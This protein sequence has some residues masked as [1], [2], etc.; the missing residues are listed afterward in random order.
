MLPSQKKLQN[1]KQLRNPHHWKF[2]E[3]LQKREKLQLKNKFSFKAKSPGN[4]AF[5]MIVSKLSPTIPIRKI[6]KGEKIP[7]VIHAFLI[8]DV[9]FING[10]IINLLDF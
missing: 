4:R 9:S 1:L 3:N 5:S 10:C 6:S 8:V 2:L 7:V